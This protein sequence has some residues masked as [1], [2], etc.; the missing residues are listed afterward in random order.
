L[1]E[2]LVGMIDNNFY[3]KIMGI[4]KPKILGGQELIYAEIIGCLKGCKKIYLPFPNNFLIKKLIKVEIKPVIK[5]DKEC[6]SIYFGTPTIV[7]NKNL[8]PNKEIWTKQKERTAVQNFCKLAKNYK[9]KKIVC[10][11]GS[12][13]ISINERKYDIYKGCGKKAELVCMKLFNGFI[14][15]VFEVE[16]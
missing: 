12:G 10:G 6:D 14:D 11:L 5:L 9:L 1:G 7:N 4:K 2:I 8:F 3:L 16:L 15:Y 13:D